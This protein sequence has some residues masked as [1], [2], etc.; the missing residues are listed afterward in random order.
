[1]PQ[2]TK[3][4][5]LDSKLENVMQSILSTS[6]ALRIVGLS[7]QAGMRPSEMINQM[8]TFEEPF[9]SPQFD[10]RRFF[11]HTFQSAPLQ[12]DFDQSVAMLVDDDFYSDAYDRTG[13][14]WPELRALAEIGLRQWRR[15]V[16]ASVVN[17]ELEDL[18]MGFSKLIRCGLNMR[19]AASILRTTAG[20]TEEINHCLA[21]LENASV[22]LSDDTNPLL[23]EFQIGLEILRPAGANCAAFSEFLAFCPS[24]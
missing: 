16:D 7:L 22:Q 13:S 21:A 18:F 23:R 24:S 10:L 5:I 2:V 19:Q 3:N 6:V 9:R 17:Q 14:D 11:P 15:T 4:E 12:S 1:L 8:P 20:W